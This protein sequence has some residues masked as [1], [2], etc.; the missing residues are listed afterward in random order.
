MRVAIASAQPTL[1]TARPAHF[2]TAPSLFLQPAGLH[3]VDDDPQSRRARPHWSIVW[4]IVAATGAVPLPRFLRYALPVTKDVLG[5]AAALAQRE[6]RAANAER[7]AQAC[8]AE[9]LTVL[10]RVG[11][12]SAW[13]AAAGLWSPEPSA[14]WS[15]L[16]RRADA[17][18]PCSGELPDRNGKITRALALSDRSQQGRATLILLGGAAQPEAVESLR[19]VLPLL[20]ALFSAEVATSAP[21]EQLIREANLVVSIARSLTSPRPLT[22]RLHACVESLVTILEVALARI[23]SLDP[24]GTTLELRAGAGL[25]TGASGPQLRVAVGESTIGRIA[26]AR[27]PYFT[28]DLAH[29]E[30]ADD[31]E[32]ARREGMVAFAGYPLRVG[33]RVVGVVALFSR[34]RLS[35]ATLRCIASI[36]D[37]I[38]V[39]LDRADTDTVAARLS[40]LVAESKDF[41][42]VAGLDNHVAF[43]NEAGRRLLGESLDGTALTHDSLLDYFSR[44]DRERARLAFVSAL[45][46]GH[47]EGEL[48]FAHFVTK[49]EIPV[50]HNIFTLKNGETGLPEMLA[51]VTRDLRPQKRSEE[52]LRALAG[53]LEQ[54]VAERTTQLRETNRELEAF[55][56]SVSHDLR[57]P[58]RH[59][60]GFVELLQKHCLEQLDAR[61]IHYLQ[62]IHLAAKQAGDLVDDLLE[63]ARMGRAE[64]ALRQVDMALVVSDCRKKV[65]A[66]AGG[67]AVE[68]SIGRLPTVQADASMMS[69]VVE[70]LLSNAMKYTRKQ[71]SPKIE[72]GYTE[73]DSDLTFFVKD[74]GV[75]FDMKHVHKLFGVFQRLHRS[76]EFEGTGIGLANVKRII[77]RHGGQ[78][79]AEGILGEGA[80]FYFTLP[81]RAG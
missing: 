62:T 19:A 18:S 65:V 21:S 49:E 73:S 56:Y 78:T 16:L 40:S 42:A 46:Q 76:E 27:A 7:L 69:L 32:W 33:E 12:Q 26:S 20:A 63:F 25:Y 44:E 29:D 8:G 75:G 13:I 57:A 81:K 15:E 47:W 74:N 60:G 14:A 38:A 5:L 39:A 70:N 9:S 53:S 79:R 23:W 58:I 72:V 77:Q 34:Q 22:V 6:E 51:T 66:A 52:A 28:N 31:P 2:S 11:E 64:I 17:E 3:S 59:I 71:L 48:R 68:W 54:R 41:V 36:A 80:T 45:Q 61:G 1:V 30:S 10:V 55:S 35:E 43:V 67:R 37:Q 50:W 24:T 4:T